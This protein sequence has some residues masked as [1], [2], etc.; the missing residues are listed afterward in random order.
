VLYST[1]L[2]PVYFHLLYE[3]NVLNSLFIFHKIQAREFLSTLGDLS[4]T[5]IFAKIE[6]VEVTAEILLS[7][8]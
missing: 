4:Q 7:H 3:K 5:Q 8:Y 6:N 2:S 1:I